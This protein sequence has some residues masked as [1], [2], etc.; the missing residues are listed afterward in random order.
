MHCHPV[1]L[2]I[3]E[4]SLNG[5]SAAKPKYFVQMAVVCHNSGGVLYDGMIESSI[6]SSTYCYAVHISKHL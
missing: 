3:S 2:I 4:I 6:V 5:I 1:R